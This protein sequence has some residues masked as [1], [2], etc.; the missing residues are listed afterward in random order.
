MATDGQNDDTRPSDNPPTG[1]NDNPE[2]PPAPP[3]A[4]PTSTQPP[5]GQGDQSAAITALTNIVNSA[6]QTITAIGEKVDGL[7]RPDTR[8]VKKPW[9]HWGSK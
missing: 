7:G 1:A 2:T 9:T 3:S 6:V 8:P 4:P 5:A